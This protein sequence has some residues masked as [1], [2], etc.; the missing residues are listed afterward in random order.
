MQIP[1]AHKKSLPR[2]CGCRCA[3]DDTPVEM[4]IGAKAT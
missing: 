4:G 1:K 3:K 2:R